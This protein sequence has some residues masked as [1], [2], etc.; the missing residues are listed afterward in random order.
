MR[1]GGERE[2]ERDRETEREREESVDRTNIYTKEG[3]K[4]F[5]ANPPILIVYT[6]FT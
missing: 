6:Y 2:R 3:N 4:T 1:G 5:F